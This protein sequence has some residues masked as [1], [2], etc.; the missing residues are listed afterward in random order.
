MVAMPAPIPSATLGS[1]AASVSSL[2][3]YLGQSVVDFCGKYGS[4]GDSV[5]H[6]AHFV[7]HLLRMRIPGAALCS[8]VGGGSTWT[9][10]ERRQG[11]CVRVDQIFNSCRNRARWNDN[12]IPSV[13]FFVIATIEAN[14]ESADPLTIGS[15]E[16]KHIGIYAGGMIYNYGN[17]QDKVRK[18]SVATFKNHYG[19]KTILLKADLP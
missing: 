15:M 5:N 9:F 18:V 17:T 19:A 12:S 7:S 3:A 16:R 2:D 4:I 13:P 11:Y 1:T 14:V 10:A 8:N 6:C